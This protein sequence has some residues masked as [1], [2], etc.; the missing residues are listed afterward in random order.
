[1]ASAPFDPRDPRNPRDPWRHTLALGLR[2]EASK[3]ALSALGLRA[4]AE[5]PVALAQALSA[6]LAAES[7]AGWMLRPLRSRTERVAKS[8]ERA[9][10]VA[11]GAFERGTLVF[12]SVSFGGEL[13]YGAMGLDVLAGERAFT[14]AHRITLGLPEALRGL[15]LVGEASARLSGPSGRLPSSIGTWC[16]HVASAAFLSI[17]AAPKDEAG[18]F[19]PPDF[20]AMPDLGLNVLRFVARFVGDGVLDLWCQAHHV[21]IDGLPLQEMLTRLASRWGSVAAVSTRGIGHVAATPSAGAPPGLV[22]RVIPNFASNEGSIIQSEPPDPPSVVT[23]GDAIQVASRP[24]DGRL[25]HLATAAVNLAPL[26]AWRRTLNQ[27]HTAALGGDAPL[28]A[29]VLWRLAGD[30]EWAGR[31]F[32]NAVDVPAGD[33]SPRAVDLISLRPDDHPRTQAGLMEFLREFRRLSALARVR[34]TP[35]YI[36]MARAA[37]LPGWLGQ[38]LLRRARGLGRQTFGSVGLSVLRDA[39]VFVAPMADHGFDEGYIA[40]GGAVFAE[41][42]R[43]FATFKGPPERAARFPA[44]FRRAIEEIPA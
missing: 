7:D 19:I 14:M 3:F 2:S 34:Q 26:V 22:V 25:V 13:S 38:F 8:K 20:A 42:G 12:L 35:T 24:A 28:A 21:G 44:A 15:R 32:A 9:G 33:R 41:S 11:L 23:P 18:R 40:L 30:P 37:R 31:R 5:D 10:D 4:P 16:T 1:M 39:A 17:E 43:A 29:L 36:A 27:A 6:F